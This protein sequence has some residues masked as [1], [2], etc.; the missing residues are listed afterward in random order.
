MW[1]RD[2]AIRSLV[3]GCNQSPHF[4]TVFQLCMLRL[5]GQVARWPGQ[6]S[7]KVFHF[8]KRT[9]FTFRLQMSPT[10]GQLS[11]Y[12]LIRLVTS[13]GILSEMFLLFWHQLRGNECHCLW[14]NLEKKRIPSSCKCKGYLKVLPPL[15][16]LTLSASWHVATVLED[17]ESAA[18]G[19]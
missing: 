12:S 2:G 18:N 3:S 6:A 14:D 5:D 4:L 19:V 17:V 15:S 9:R 10:H 11:G 1:K 16:C 8:E 13:R 7:L